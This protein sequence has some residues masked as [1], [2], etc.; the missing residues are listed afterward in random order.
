MLFA[1]AAWTAL[2]AAMRLS[3]RELQIAQGIFADHKESTIAAALSMS[4]HTVRTHM[5]RLYH[6]LGVRSRTEL[7][8]RIVGRFL[9]L[10]AE[11]DSQL[12]P[13]CG[14]R[15]GGRCPFGN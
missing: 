1:P 12:P 8:I 13:I 11:A 7:V 9:S 3:P 6:K 14:K 15:T 10:T 5:E 4:P 2:G